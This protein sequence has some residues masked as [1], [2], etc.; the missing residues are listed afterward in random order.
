MCLTGF[1]PRGDQT[2]DTEVSGGFILMFFDSAVDFYL[3]NCSHM[4]TLQPTHFTTIRSAF[5]IFPHFNTTMSV[6]E[7]DVY[8]FTCFYEYTLYV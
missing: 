3:V 4:S 7:T 1:E 6:T 2:Q 8:F 5:I